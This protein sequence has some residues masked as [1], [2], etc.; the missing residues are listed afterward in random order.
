VSDAEGESSESS[1]TFLDENL[2]KVCA[3]AAIDCVLLECGHMVTCT[4]CGK[5]LAECPICRRY[6]SRVVHVF[7]A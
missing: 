4:A 5:R 1:K 3:D 6:V 2:C 7:R